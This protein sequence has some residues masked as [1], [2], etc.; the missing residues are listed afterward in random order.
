MSSNPAPVLLNLLLVGGKLVRWLTKP[1]IFPSHLINSSAGSFKSWHRKLTWSSTPSHPELRLTHPVCSV[2]WDDEYIYRSE[3]KFEVTPSR[4]LKQK[5]NQLGPAEPWSR[6]SVYLRNMFHF[7]DIRSSMNAMGCIQSL[8]Y[9]WCCLCAT[10]PQPLT[11]I[12][13]WT[14]LVQNRFI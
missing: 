8:I 1:L 4:N 3:P 13:V 11:F 10:S 7:C 5:F 6:S 12:G 2:N 9:L 14:L